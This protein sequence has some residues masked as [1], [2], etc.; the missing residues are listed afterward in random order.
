ME[1]EQHYKDRKLLF[2][3]NK[4]ID[5]TNNIEVM[6]DWED[7]IMYEH[8]KA[9]CQNGGDILEIGF[10]M[11]ISAT[12]IQSFNIK[13]H[14]IME[15]HPQILP[16]LKEWSMDKENITIIEGDW[17]N[18]LDKLKNYDGIF[19]DTFIDENAINKKILLNYLNDN[20]IFTWY[21]F[22]FENNSHNLDVE[23]INIKITPD[24]N[25]YNN[26]DYYS[27]PIYRNEN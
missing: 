23:Y 14:T 13:S 26:N 25:K 5:T 24:K 15:L 7:E 21:N 12:H 2:E 9:V 11:G 16:R 8:A 27:V 6:M 18:N 4:I 22:L 19:F 10:G 17:Y 1:M 20:G 3:D